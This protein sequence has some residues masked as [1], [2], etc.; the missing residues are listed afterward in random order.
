MTDSGYRGSLPPRND[1]LG[2]PWVLVV[3]G[4]FILIL[5]LN[6]A[7]LPANLFPVAT[8]L[9]LPSASAV[10]SASTA[11]SASAEASASVVASASTAPSASPAP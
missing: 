2:R 10:A 8:P 1:E 5:I 3:L 9:P 7:G 4:V 11:P 6:F